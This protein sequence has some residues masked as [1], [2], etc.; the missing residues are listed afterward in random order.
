MKLKSI[1]I[2]S[3]YVIFLINTLYVCSQQSIKVLLEETQSF[4]GVWSLL[5]EEVYIALKYTKYDA[6]LNVL[7]FGSGTSTTELSK[8]FIKKNVPY[9]YHVFENDINYVQ[10]IE[11]VFF[12][13]YDLPPST[14]CDYSTWIN[15]ISCIELPSMPCFDLV[16]VDGPHGI[17]RAQ[18]YSKFKKYTR[19]GTIILV[20]DFHHYSDFG[21]ELDRNFKYT[22][23]IEYN[24]NPAYPIVN[25]GLESIN[26]RI[27]NKTFK[28]V[29]VDEVLS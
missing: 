16:I 23:I 6:V 8:L 20:D 14:T 25:K 15:P 12:Y 11:K 10:E 2:S 24:Q 3:L 26:N 4:P 22:T 27:L 19:Q 9:E 7:E 29:I 1:F 5:P 17:A 13:L 18:W 21:L 28:I